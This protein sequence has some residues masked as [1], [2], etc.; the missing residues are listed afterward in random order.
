MPTTSIDTS[1]ATWLEDRH[2][3]HGI[4]PHTRMLLSVSEEEDGGTTER[5]LD[6]TGAT[7]INDGLVSVGA[8]GSDDALPTTVVTTTPPTRHPLTRVLS[9][10]VRV[11][12]GSLRASDA[13][14]LLTAPDAPAEG[15]GAEPPAGHGVAGP[16]RPDRDARNALMP[17]S[18]IEALL[19]DT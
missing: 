9:R 12:T 14:T 4:A 11:S 5:Y 8:H 16:G 13:A 15:E 18:E 2:D 1:G 6:L 7:V 3:P 17:I 10:T 19:A